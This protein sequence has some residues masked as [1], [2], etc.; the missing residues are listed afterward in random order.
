MLGFPQGHARTVTLYVHPD[1]LA[2]QVRWLSALHPLIHLL[3]RALEGDTGLG[4]LQLP[5]AAMSD[6]APRLIR[7]AQIPR[8]TRHEFASLAITSDVLHT[9][10]QLARPLRL[11]SYS[12]G[13]H[14]AAPR[15]E[16]S[17]AMSL[18]STDLQRPWRMEDL[19]SEVALSRARRPG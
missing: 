16:V 6:L 18:L 12:N 2:D 15:R 3:R 10:G 17:G 7:L 1:Y 11:G 13:V 9:V 14:L 5:T 19:A 8:A 4:L